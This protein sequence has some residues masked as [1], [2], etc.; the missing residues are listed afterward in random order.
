MDHVYNTNNFVSI[1]LHSWIFIH[2]TSIKATPD[3]VYSLSFNSSFKCLCWAILR[4]TIDY[5]AL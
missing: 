2:F 1:I 4:A 3:P 5:I